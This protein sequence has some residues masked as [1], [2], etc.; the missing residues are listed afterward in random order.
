M[1]IFKSRLFRILL[2]S[3]GVLAFAGYFAFSTFLFPPHEAAWEYDL[4][5]LIPRD[6]DF[7]V[8]KAELER[9]FD[10]FPHV[11]G[12]AELQEHDA[13]KA[14]EGSPTWEQLKADLD[15]DNQL[16][17]L[18]ANLARIPL[19]MGPLDIFGGEDVSLAG[20]FRGADLEQADWAVYGRVNWAGKL[21]VS[22]LDYPG[23]LGL[24]AQGIQVENG[25]KWL[26]LSGSTLKRPLYVSRVQDIVVLSS[27]QALAEGAR[28]LA[29]EGSTDSLWLSARYQ[30]R[31]HSS[32]RN[33]R[34]DEV[35]YF[36]DVKKLLEN[37]SHTGPL[38]DPGSHYLQEALIARLVQVPAISE[39]IGLLEV[40][41]G[42]SLDVHG[43]LSSDKVTDTMGKLYR[44]RGFER[45]ELLAGPAWLAP[46]D[47]VLF[48]YLHGP[49]GEILRQI[50][51]SLEP[52]A[53]QNVEDFFVSTGVYSGGVQQVISDLE[54][55][56]KNRLALIVRPND[57]KP[58]PKAEGTVGPPPN[59]GSPVFSTTLAAWLG[60]KASDKVPIVELRDTI[61]QH[62][63]KLGLQGEGPPGTN[64]FYSYHSRGLETREYWQPLIPGTGVI[65]SA[66][67]SE[68]LFVS[69]T[70]AGPGH[71]N[72]TYLQKTS[73]FPSLADR[74]DF[75]ALLDDSLPDAN[76]VVWFRPAAGLE[77]L[78]AQARIA[79]E[80]NALRGVDW[81][82]PRAKEENAVL[83][84]QFP[85]RSK[86]SLDEQERARFDSLVNGRLTL[87]RDEMKAER[88]PELLR[89]AERNLTYLESLSSALLMLRLDP[90][91]FDLSMRVIVPVD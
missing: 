73:E 84:A 28:T 69:N 86:S 54:G 72:Q 17:R 33:A 82:G 29:A 56:L 65:L 87:L 19:G 47:T 48:V 15:L 16:T 20:Y 4:T 51:E 53:R 81:A 32:N 52:A 40:E 26:S 10:E 34:E 7:Y 23:V 91:E 14:F 85:G 39:A 70:V 11:V 58:T 31:I 43:S 44:Q 77:T 62:G 5:S 25:G 59:D 89:A 3:G 6:V 50:F 18:E 41:A 21:A 63:P 80:M 66:V 42:L 9:D 79:A 27:S 37:L 30:D 55:S 36:V 46:A 49:V 88:T 38:P 24:P 83:Q 61:G 68:L 35:E 57:Y 1:R 71:V 12:E 64:G 78:R 8:A 22:L 2:T 67:T 45:S 75:Q 76:V 74:P 13:W 90:K 60:D